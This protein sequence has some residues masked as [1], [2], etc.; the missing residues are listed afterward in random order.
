MGKFINRGL[1]GFK[2]YTNGDY[3]DKTGL[4][5]YVN[6][7]ISTADMLTCVTRPRRFGKT[8]AAQMLYAYYDKYSNSRHLFENYQIAQHPTFEQHL[9]KYP[10]LYID[11]TN[12]TTKYAGKKN[13][14]ILMQKDIM[15]DLSTAF[16][17]IKPEEGDD[18][19]DFLLSIATTTGEKF[20]MIID[21]WDA[22]C[23]EAGDNT[24]IM[25]D[26]M[27][28]LRRLFK[29][30]D[31][32]RV[33]ACAYMTGILPVKK[34]G[35]QSALNDFV[36][37][38]MTSPRQLAGYIGFTENEVKAL[39]DKYGMDYED[40]KGWYD[41]YCFGIGYPPV[42]NPNSVMK[43]CSSGVFENYWAKT[44]AFEAL[45]Q[46]IDLELDGIKESLECIIK[47]D[48]QSVNTLRFG[49]DLY[50]VGSNEEFLTLLIHLGYLSYN[51]EYKTVSLPNKEIRMEF[52]ESLRSSKNH[53]RLV[54]IVKTSDRLLEATLAKNETVVAELI[55]KLHNHQASPDF[56]NNE[57]A[58]RSVLKLGYLSAID[59]FVTI[60]ELPSGKGYADLV[61]IPRRDSKAPVVIIELKWN[62]PAYT[63]IRQI[64]DRNY[65]DALRGFTDN[66]LL[67]GISYDTETKQH[68]CKIEMENVTK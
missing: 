12:F 20:V 64:R 28:F 6:S 52:T 67:V 5:G 57:Q 30:S 62:Q 29:G 4:I 44:E 23:R 56:Y 60:Q 53:A 45:Q 25:K 14:V 17:D 61:L 55:E 19:M 13:L 58:L 9:N 3:V 10:T 68:T 40:M 34:Y 41:G 46:Y 42:F 51:V 66:I 27:D 24:G 48:S 43:A 50:A 2:R 7:T 8:A 26:Y 36:E 65:P 37:F 11:I 47:G 54:E 32:A 22:I 49:S 39:C 1:E 35:T 33:F 18:L 31:V 63:A 59:H 15:K 38:S 16:P 21:E